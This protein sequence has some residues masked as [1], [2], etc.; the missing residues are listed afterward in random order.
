[1][2]K[3]LRINLEQ[4]LLLETT[5]FRIEENRLNILKDYA[6]SLI[7]ILVEI[8]KSAFKIQ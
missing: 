7:L 8:S 5:H 1:M 6:I 4:W 3:N 2:K